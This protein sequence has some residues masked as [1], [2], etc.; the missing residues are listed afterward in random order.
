MFTRDIEYCGGNGYTHL[1]ENGRHT[2]TT[3]MSILPCAPSDNACATYINSVYYHL[4]EA[5]P[6]S[7]QESATAIQAS[8]IDAVPRFSLP[9][10]SM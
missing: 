5:Q 3:S 8:H 4:D 1:G 10:T 6:T 2:D 7:R 9:S